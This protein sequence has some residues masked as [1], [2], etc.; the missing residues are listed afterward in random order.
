MTNEMLNKN[1]ETLKQGT[2]EIAQES[3]RAIVDVET[4]QKTNQDIIDTLD[5][6]IAIHEAG[7]EKRKEAEVELQNIEGQLKEKLLEIKTEK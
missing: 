3:E 1:S 7:R 5:Q 6:L 2:I 4:L